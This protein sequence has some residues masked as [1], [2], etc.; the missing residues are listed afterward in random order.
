MPAAAGQITITGKERV[1]FEREFTIVAHTLV[2]FVAK[3][4]FVRTRKG[5]DYTVIRLTV[6]KKAAQEM[7]LKEEDYM[8]LQGRVAEWYDMIDWNKMQETWARLPAG[9]QQQILTSGLGPSG[10]PVPSVPTPVSRPQLESSPV[11]VSAPP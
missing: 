5:K 8:F 1:I 11:A 9:V 6:P 2:P 3:T 7:G 10:I 4:H